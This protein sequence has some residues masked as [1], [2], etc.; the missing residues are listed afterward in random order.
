LHAITQDDIPVNGQQRSAKSTGFCGRIRH[1]AS[2]PPSLCSRSTN[3][4]FGADHQMIG[5]SESELSHEDGRA[6]NRGQA[7]T[8]GQ[9]VDALRRAAQHD[10]GNAAK[11]P[12][13]CDDQ[14]SVNF[15]RM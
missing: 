15:I 2:A 3:A 6:L 11:T 4:R 10:T 13:P 12:P 7:S 5:I 9:M 1:I 8:F 14:I